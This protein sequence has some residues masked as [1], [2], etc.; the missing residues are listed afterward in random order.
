MTQIKSKLS[1]AQRSVVINNGIVTQGDGTKAPTVEFEVIEN[2]K[3]TS[4]TILDAEE[5]AQAA[6]GLNIEGLTYTPPIKLPTGLGALIQRKPN[7][8]GPKYDWANY[9]VLTTD[10]WYCG[11]ASWSNKDALDELTKH[12]GTIIFEGVTA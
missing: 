2:G 5:F 6:A 9:V 12:G 1:P 11:T 7:P 8:S 10:G 3:Y 4:F